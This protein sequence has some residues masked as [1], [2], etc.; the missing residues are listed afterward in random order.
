MQVNAMDAMALHVRARLLGDQTSCSPHS[1]DWRRT[2]VFV[3]GRTI[4][5]QD[6]FFRGGIDHG[7]AQS[8]LGLNCEDS[9]GPTYECAIPIQ[10]RNLLNTTTSPWKEGD[11]FLDWYDQREPSQN[12]WSH[13]IQA[14]GTAV[15]WSTNNP[16]HGANMATE[17]YGYEAFNDAHSLGDHYWMMD[18]DMDCSRAVC[19]NGEAWFELKSYISNIPN[20]WERAISQAG[21]PYGSGNHFAKCGQINIFRRHMS[22]AIF[23][24]FP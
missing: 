20:G 8:V 18:V 23:F 2:V 4:E 10:H 1:P 24:D 9:N 3:Y 13:G 5:G 17:G 11:E 16:S 22:E 15:D 21:A 19:V 14:Q 6:M 7:Y 12:G